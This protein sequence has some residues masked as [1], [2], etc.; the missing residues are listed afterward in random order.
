MKKMRG[1]QA[2][3]TN[4]TAS[5]LAEAASYTIHTTAIRGSTAV[6]EEVI[7]LCQT[8]TNGKEWPKHRDRKQVRN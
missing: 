6:A 7:R 3:H 4:M 8:A 2:A 5:E 1:A